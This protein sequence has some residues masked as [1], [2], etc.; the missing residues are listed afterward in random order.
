MIR[1]LTP[2][3][4]LR[5]ARRWVGLM[6]Q[7]A[8]AKQVGVSAQTVSR[9]ERSDFGRPVTATT[10]RRLAEALVPS[11]AV[12]ENSSESAGAMTGWRWRLLEFFG[13]LDE[14]EA[15][16][17]ELARFLTPEEEQA[18]HERLIEAEPWRREDDDDPPAAEP[19]IL[20]WNA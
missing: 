6:S 10:I 4:Y 17:L 13:Y 14:A 3:Q 16:R 9:W 8:L 11:E 20:Y 15:E 1:D 2:G 12:E 19:Q 5:L 18:L 7:A